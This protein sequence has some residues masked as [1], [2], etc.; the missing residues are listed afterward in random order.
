MERPTRRHVLTTSLFGLL[1]ACSE[2][3]ALAQLSVETSLGS[4]PTMNWEHFIEHLEK[5]AAQ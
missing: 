2:L 5:A 3:P 4:A 1:C